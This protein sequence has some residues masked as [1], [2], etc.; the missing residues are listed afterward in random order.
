MNVK[1]IRPDEE[2]NNPNNVIST[3]KAGINNTGIWQHRKKD[4]TMVMVNMITHDIIYQGKH[5][6]LV[7][8]NDMTEKIIAEEKLKNSHAEF[9][10]WL[11]TFRISGKLNHTHGPGDT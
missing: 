8:S 7:L 3:Y 9:V 1:D 4:G 6:K 11:H 5:A 10:S 2:D